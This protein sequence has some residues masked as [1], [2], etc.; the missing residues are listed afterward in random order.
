M[1]FLQLSNYERANLFSIA[2]PGETGERDFRAMIKLLF[3]IV[4]KYMHIYNIDICEISLA[5]IIL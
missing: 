1:R 5:L 3:T 4:N 2:V